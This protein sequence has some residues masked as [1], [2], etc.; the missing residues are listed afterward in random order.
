MSEY[1]APGVY[2]EDVNTTPVIQSVSTTTGGF[3]GT[4]QRGPLNKPVFISSWNAFL[5]TFAYGM[6][7]P[8]L[9]NSDLAYAV[10]GFFQNGGKRCYVMRVASDT[11]KAATAT[12]TEEPGELAVSAKDAGAW[13]NALKLKVS[14]NTDVPENFD[15]TVIYNSEVVEV[16]TNVGNTPDTDNYWIDVVNAQSNYI[17]ATAGALA[18]NA[19]AATFSGGADGVSDIDDADY[20]S[21]LAN[22]DTVTDM[23]LLCIPGQTS[24]EMN[25]ALMDY[26]EGR[27][28]VFAILDAPKAST[29]ESVRELRKQMSCKCGALF[30]P[31]IRVT[32]PTSSGKLR[33]CPTCGHVMGVYAR[34][35]S[36]RGVWK[37]PAG[38]E[39]NIRGAVEVLTTLTAGDLDVLNPA[40]IISIIPKTN[41]GI[42]IWGARNLNPDSSMKYVSDVLLDTFIK[43]SIYEGT[44]QYV[45]EPNDTETW[46]RLCI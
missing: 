19:T 24:K 42:V 12:F 40:G 23:S 34:I 46:S 35:I 15:I 44:Q 18:S 33:D 9:S 27:S 2:I 11:A 5:N 28:D 25:K 43:K 6:L 36:E 29:V 3:V 10:Y 41:Y 4:C 31:W 38:T 20:S 21:A 7:T 30:F 32:D 39:A 8:F 17:S 26:C 16:F 45:F 14:A 22:F 37:V 1:L 13:G